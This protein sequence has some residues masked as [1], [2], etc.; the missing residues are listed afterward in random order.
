MTKAAAYDQ[1][2]KEFYAARLQEDV[3]RRVA[4]EEAQAT[5]AYFGK[6]MLQIGMELEDEEYER[7][8][9]WGLQQ[10]AQQE[11]A[12]AAIYTGVDNQAMAVS[13]DDPE[14]QAGLEELDES[15]PDKGQEALG[16]APVTT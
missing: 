1:A 3:E 13:I 2:R 4:K 15:I 9:E 10:I 12:R 16:G 7:W 11:Q 6:S 8:R 5:G 14:T